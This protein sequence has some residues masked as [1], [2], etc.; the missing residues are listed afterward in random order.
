[1]PDDTFERANRRAKQLGISRSAFF[2]T[3]AARYLAQLDR[4][5]LTARIDQSLKLIGED[6]DSEAAATAGR[7][8]LA[9]AEW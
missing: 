8:R 1:M 7:R 3:A 4:E 6:R 5:S 2:A 9:Q